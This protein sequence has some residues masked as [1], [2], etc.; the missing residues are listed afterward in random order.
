L[1]NVVI[2]ELKINPDISQGEG[3]ATLAELRVA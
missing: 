2:L 3:L 1:T